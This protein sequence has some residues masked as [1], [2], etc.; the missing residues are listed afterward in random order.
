MNT[1]D[2]IRAA[3]DA[4]EAD[5]ETIGEYRPAYNGWKN[6]ETWSTA[7][8]MDNDQGTQEASREI[9][10]KAFA[11]DPFEAFRAFTGHEPS[12]G[13]EGERRAKISHAADA[14]REWWTDALDPDDTNSA[15]PLGDLI[16]NALEHVDWYAIAEGY[17]EDL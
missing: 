7:L 10:A 2:S 11:A 3:L 8:W 6:Y 15:G 9:V 16:G 12:G 4:A 17:A 13:P 1:T 5:G 14:L